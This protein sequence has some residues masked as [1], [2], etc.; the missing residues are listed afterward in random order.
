[1]GVARQPQTPAK[2]VF[3]VLGFGL[4]PLLLLAVFT[5]GAIGHRYGFD[6]RTFWHAARLVTHGASPYPD[7]SVVRQAHLENGDY[8]YFV[9]PPPF[10][11]ALLPLASLP[12]AVAAAL[13]TVILLACLAGSLFVLEVRDWRCYGVVVAA[14]PVLSA[15]RLGAVTPVL[16][17]LAAC[18]WRFRND[19]WKG[20][21][22]VGAAI[23]L[24]LFLWP[25][26][27]WLL[28]TRRL[29]AAA[30]ALG[31]ALT[32]SAVGWFALRFDGLS[33]YPT[34]LKTLSH[35]EGPES[36]SLVALLDRLH[37]A[38]PS[39]N[40]LLL[41]LPLT[42][43]LAASCVVIRPGGRDQAAFV[44]AVGMALFLTPIT[45]LNYFALLAVPVAIR[46]TTLSWEW[47]VLLLFWLTPSPEPTARPLW[48][49]AWA[50]G[51]SVLVTWR[52]QRDPL[53]HFRRW[54]VVPA[55]AHRSSS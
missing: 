23:V 4:T 47:C 16:M 41:A 17:L 52:C 6:F 24:K 50:L 35:I 55:R 37:V 34:L 46:R 36:Y 49:I 7:P 43:L 31:G 27:L 26:A 48:Q 33:D 28:A 51:L 13:W 10:A 54:T 1:M 53:T 30:I 15:V 11:F 12:F 19:A 5:I 9:Y 25:L 40:W 32:A 29:R 42:L 38:D 14:V 22:A 39:R 8:E 2:S 3:G 18:A 20:G 44:T 45:W 21:A